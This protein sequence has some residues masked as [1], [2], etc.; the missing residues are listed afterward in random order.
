[1][2]QIMNIVNFVRGLEPR[3]EMD[4]YT[5][6]VEQ[7][8]YNKKYNIPNTFL[9]QYD[10]MLRQDFR[11]LFL[12]ER[13][14]KM[15][16]GVWFE[17]CRDLI[18][19]IG[20][21]WRGRPGY[22]WDWFVNVGFLEGYTPA[23]R[24]LIVDEVFR[25]FKEIFG[26]YPQVV[27]SWVMDAHSM[28][29][30]CQKYDIKAFCICREQLAVDAYTLWGG[31]SN[32]GY[33]PSKNNM[34]CPAQTQEN[35]ILAPVFRMLM[36][37]PIYNYDGQKYDKYDDPIFWTIEPAWE[38]GQIP[39]LADWYFDTYYKTPCLTHAEA[40]TGQEN[41][42]GW[43]VFGEGYCMQIDKLVALEKEGVVSLQKLGDTGVW[44]QENFPISAATAQVALKDWR[45]N[46]LKTVWYNCK[47]YRTNFLLVGDTL[48]VRDLTKYDDRYQERYLE[49]PCEGWLATY[50]N[51]PIVDSRVWSKDGKVCELRF[52][53]QVAAMDANE[54]SDTVLRLKLNFADGTT[55]DV[56]LSEEGVVFENCGDLAY[57]WGVPTEYT[58]LAFEG[59][60]LKGCQNGFAYEMSVEGNVI[61]NDDG[62]ILQPENGTLS[63]KLDE[64][65]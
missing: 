28:D 54:D 21:E 40:T 5:P 18:E 6:V 45:G 62:F 29:Y 9:L 20:L 43:H 23:E 12:Q 27:G 55:G 47:N 38:S 52:V 65:A 31:Y 63:L 46:D 2:K 58:S 4:L 14:E 51:L 13:D 41:S 60:C 39:S 19:T 53:K 26:E 15:E 7:I 34:I 8:K 49:V 50:D 36:S 25:L 3:C 61:K 10:A 16:L 57:S 22:D 44:Y 64:R 37:D 33:Y 1:M 24:E 17:N 30:M 56:V 59:N 42:F 35:K 48:L 11:D 32:G